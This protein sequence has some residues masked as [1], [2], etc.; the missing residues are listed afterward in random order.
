MAIVK[1]SQAYHVRPLLAVV[2]L[3]LQS[4]VLGIALT[5]NRAEILFSCLAVRSGEPFSGRNEFR[6]SYRYAH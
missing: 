2:T 5:T 1:I 4:R 3:R 6:M